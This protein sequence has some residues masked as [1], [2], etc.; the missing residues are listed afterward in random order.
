[1]D[2]KSHLTE[3]LDQC[4]VMPSFHEY[5]VKRLSPIELELYNLLHTRTESKFSVNLENL[6]E[7]IG[8]ASKGNAKKRVLKQYKMDIDYII[9]PY[10]DND[11]VKRGGH[12]RELI[13]LTEECAKSFI[14]NSGIRKSK[15]LERF[16]REMETHRFD[17]DRL[18]SMYRFK[19]C[20]SATRAIN[21]EQKLLEGC[22]EGLKVFY[23]GYIGSYDGE[24][25][26]KY[27]ISDNP[28][29]RVKEH[30]R[31]Y[32]EFY[33][34]HLSKDIDHQMMEKSVENHPQIVPH[35]RVIEKNDVRHRELI[36]LSDAFKEDDLMEVVRELESLL[37]TTCRCKSDHEQREYLERQQI[38]EHE[39]ELK[40][41]DYA[42]EEKRLVSEQKVRDH[43]M[44]KL[45]WQT[46]Y[47]FLYA[48]YAGKITQ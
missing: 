9:L 15:D 39:I 36:A 42:I 24:I 3:I 34:F 40:R 32:G 12:N 4:E 48:T 47:V 10:V 44:Q 35:R 28:R 19:N 1:M 38:R 31:T 8:F 26:V 27:G 30:K 29:R 5:L 6:R 21:K 14:C 18:I 45:K 22:Y 16:V 33:L 41:L 20:L 13:L 46:L 2:S 37:Q 43:E 25:I 7:I 17:Y 11:T 23:M